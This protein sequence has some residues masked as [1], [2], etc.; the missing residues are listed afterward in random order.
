MAKRWPVL[1]SLWLAGTQLT[2]AIAQDSL[3]ASLN[4]KTIGL[5]VADEAWLP[6]ARNFA[7]GL[8]HVDGLRILPILGSGSVQALSDLSFLQ[9]V[10]AAILSSDAIS[11]ANQ[12]GLLNPKTYRLN[13]TAKL[14]ALNV[15][16]VARSSF[17][18]LSSLNGKRIATGP[19]HS[20]AYATGE[21]LFGAL[22]LDFQR[23]ALSENEGMA[24]LR[25]GKADAALMLGS[26][27]EK[28]GLAGGQWK[29]I[30]VPLI[31]SL[32]ET[33]APALLVADDFPGLIEPGKSVDT[34]SAA[35]ILA[36]FNWP[37]GSLHYDKLN[38]FTA[39]LYANPALGDADRGPINLATQVAGWSRYSVVD[40][41]IS[42]NKGDNP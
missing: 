37:K 1:V 25:N 29:I 21:I 11:Y 13:Y 18:T 34:I 17:T 6:I 8:D 36:V 14:D 9:G 10:D 33:Y 3:S 39:A 4:K 22:G 40:D 23:V 31:P 35:L 28:S 2:P 41:I 27:F 24:A 32:Q 5:M 16:L 7:H 19:V 26:S 12:H 42:S 38:A 20:S 30:S 15:V